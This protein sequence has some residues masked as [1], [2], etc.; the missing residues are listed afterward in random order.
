MASKSDENQL[1]SSYDWYY[2]IENRDHFDRDYVL[3]C[4]RM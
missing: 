2:Q 4:K 1:R 3:K